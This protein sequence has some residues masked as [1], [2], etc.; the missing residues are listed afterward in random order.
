M[1]QRPWPPL[2][3][4]EFPTIEYFACEMKIENAT[5]AAK[6]TLTVPQSETRVS[7]ENGLT[8]IL[9]ELKGTLSLEGIEVS[10]PQG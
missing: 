6:G 3:A 7:D 4:S 2:Q 8:G 10:D 5:L 1:K 9:K